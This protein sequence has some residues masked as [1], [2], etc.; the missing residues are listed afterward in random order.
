MQKFHEHT[1]ALG[2]TTLVRLSPPSALRHLTRTQVS[3][4][5]FTLLMM[6]CNHMLKLGTLQFQLLV[7]VSMSPPLLILKYMISLGSGWDRCQVVRI[8]CS[9]VHSRYLS[10]IVG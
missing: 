2:Q 9:D 5:A 8:L 6:V 10:P 3:R 4:R 7:G 1:C